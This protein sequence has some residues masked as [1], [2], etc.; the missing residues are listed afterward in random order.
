MS[1][2]SSIIKKCLIKDI[3]QNNGLT[4]NELCKSIGLALPTILKFTSELIKKGWVVETE[5]KDSTGGRKPKILS[6][7]PE[8]IHSI[9]IDI[10]INSIKGIL[11]N[12]EGKIYNKLV[13]KLNPN[14]SVIAQIK[15]MI[16]D[17]IGKSGKETIKCIGIGS[18]GF[19]DFKSGTSIYSPHL[20]GLENVPVKEIIEKEFEIY[21]VLDDISRGLAIAEK[22]SGVAKEI[23]NFIFLFIDYG[24]GSGIFING[25]F[26]RGDRGI[27]GELGHIKVT[28]NGSLCGC[29]NR[30][31]L[32]T[33]I[34]I[35]SII[36]HVKEGLENGVN[37][38][39]NE[40]S[41]SIDNILKS[42]KEGDKLAFNIITEAS[43]YL[44]IAIANVLNLF[45]I[46]T[47]ILAGN[48]KE[49]S[50][51]IVEPVKRAIKFHSL[52]PIANKIDIRISSLN[53]EITGALGMGIIASD[54][55]F[56]TDK[57]YDIKQI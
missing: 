17:I 20:S 14:I 39:L 37:S 21:T 23:N 54:M 30:G 3:K 5:T 40:E 34:S 38:S 11:C 6:I 42:A 53:E 16:K 41:I 22:K 36:R 55:L 27:S 52:S 57:I 43:E 1:N 13:K 44:G 26:L 4:R 18:P 48:P 56:K 29:G 2:I 46:E 19:V 32:E 7:N 10:G 31:C 24:I 35:P 50:E 15:S 25:E 45:G 47:V 28:E 8:V 12:F 9:G 33:F 49:I 51:F